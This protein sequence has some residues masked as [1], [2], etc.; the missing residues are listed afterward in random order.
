MKKIIV[1]LL[2]VWLALPTY[3]RALGL[4]VENPRMDSSGVTWYDATSSYNGPG[5]TI[6]RVLPPTNPASGM[7]HRFIYVLPVIV[8]VDLQNLFGDGLEELLALNVHND[9]NQRSGRRLKPSW[10]SSATLRCSC[11][12]QCSLAKEGSSASQLA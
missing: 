2:C 7:P 11:T 3:A 12:L 4:I 8:D 5:S 6:L 10:V 9:Y 1:P